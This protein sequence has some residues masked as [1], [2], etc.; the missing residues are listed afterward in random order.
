M[1]AKKK[2]PKHI[3][4]CCQVCIYPKIIST[5]CLLRFGCFGPI[6]FT[7]DSSKNPS[8]STKIPDMKN[9]N[10]NECKYYLRKQNMS[11]K[12]KHLSK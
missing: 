7:L 11:I 6:Q 2:C 12:V 1:L 5:S 3:Y 9:K 4:R 8:N 10:R